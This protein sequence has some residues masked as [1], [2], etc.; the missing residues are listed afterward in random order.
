MPPTPNNPG[1]GIELTNDPEFMHLEPRKALPYFVNHLKQVG[2]LITVNLGSRR[3]IV[4]R[5]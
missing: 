2:N 3:V 1:P 4:R 5:D